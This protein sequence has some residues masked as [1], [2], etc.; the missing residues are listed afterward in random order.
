MSTS[1]SIYETKRKPR[2][3]SAVFELVPYVSSVLEGP[4]TRFPARHP[5]SD[6]RS[7]F[8]ADWARTVLASTTGGSES[9]KH[10][11]QLRDKIDDLSSSME[12]LRN[13][14]A[15]CR[16]C[17]DSL[18]SAV[19]D[20]PLI[21]ETRLVEIAAELEVIEPIPVV[22]EES[23]DEVVASFPELEVFAV[24]AS[25]AEAISSLK[26]EIRGLYY[27]LVD[28]PDEQLGRVPQTWK[29]VLA[30]VVKTVG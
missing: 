26:T 23:E 24:G 6:P 22:I 8:L 2:T 13:D 9:D 29:R 28:T 12:L 7:M 10:I 19:T 16:A 20:K 21:K 30:K 17:L 18:Y 1:H 25:E 11:A 14:V 5:F 27:E 4:K 3:S 15:S